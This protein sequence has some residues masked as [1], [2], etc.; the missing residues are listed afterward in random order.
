MYKNKYIPIK[1][2]QKT[3][4]KFVSLKYVQLCLINQKA[5]KN[6]IHKEIAFL[7]I[8]KFKREKIKTANYVN[9]SIFC[10]NPNKY[11]KLN[12]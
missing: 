3:H 9:M 7:I 4:L 10:H 1:I 12:F 2:K 11:I 6:F 8:L 5:E